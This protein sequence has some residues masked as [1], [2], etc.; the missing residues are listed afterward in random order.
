MI[1]GNDKGSAN[2]T[3]AISHIW[4]HKDLF[5]A[6]DFKDSLVGFYIG[7]NTAGKNNVSHACALQKRLNVFSGHNL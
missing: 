3:A 6:V 5:Y 2:R 7:Y 4:M 1:V